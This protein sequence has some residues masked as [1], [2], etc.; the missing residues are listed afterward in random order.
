MGHNVKN[1]KLDVQK[2][3]LKAIF[4]HAFLGLLGQMTNLL[5]HLQV[6]KMVLY[7]EIF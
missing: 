6:H 7:L 1:T 5:Q 4:D 3:R 2:E